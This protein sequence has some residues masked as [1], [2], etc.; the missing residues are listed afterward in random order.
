[1]KKIT[2]GDMAYCMSCERKTHAIQIEDKTVCI[3]CLSDDLVNEQGMTFSPIFGLDVDKSYRASK[4]TP[5]MPDRRKNSGSCPKFKERR[6]I[7]AT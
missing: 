1:M 3:Y 2:N 7:Y 6:E 5:L 4:Y